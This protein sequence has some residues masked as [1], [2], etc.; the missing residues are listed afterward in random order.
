MCADPGARTPIGASR[1]Y[2]CYA[3]STL[4]LLVKIFLFAR[5]N[6][7]LQNHLL[8]IQ[9]FHNLGKFRDPGSPRS[10]LYL[11]LIILLQISVYCIYNKSIL[12]TI[13]IN[14]FYPVTT[15]IL[16]RQ[17]ITLAIIVTITMKTVTCYRHV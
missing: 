16:V 8:L 12:I 4:Y 2:P 13:F 5:L 10:P 3:F 6:A 1:N 15:T 9:I 7:F 14:L 11:C 17:V